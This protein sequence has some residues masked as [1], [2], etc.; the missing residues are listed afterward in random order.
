MNFFKKKSTRRAAAIISSVL[1][2]VSAFTA[3]YTALNYMRINSRG[4]SDAVVEAAK[5][6]AFSGLIAGFILIGLSVVIMIYVI[7]LGGYNENEGKFEIRMRDRVP[8]ELFFIS[9][10]A[11]IT[12]L[13]V[14][15]EMGEFS[16][17]LYEL[18]CRYKVDHTAT[19]FVITAVLTFIYTAAVFSVDSLIN[20][21]KCHCVSDTFFFTRTA[22][23]IYRKICSVIALRKN[24]FAVKFFIRLGLA[25][26][27]GVISVLIGLETGEIAVLAVLCG[28]TVYGY[29]YFSIRD[30]KDVTALTG[31]IE[32]ISRGE[33]SQEEPDPSSVI[34]SAAVRLN[35]ISD[36]IR[37][38]VEEQLRSERMKIELVTNV[39][40][41]LKT[42]LTSVIS[43]VDLL[44]KEELSPVAQDYVAVLEQK[45]DRL[46]TIVSDVFDLAKATS[47]TDVC[48]ETI[49][50]VIL[51][52]QVA[53]DMEDKIKEYGREVRLSVNAETAFIEAE[54]K[55]MYRVLQNITDNALKYSLEGT[56][57]YLQLDVNDGKVLITVKNIASYEMN[58]TPEEITERF[59][60]GDKSRTTEGS[61]LGLAIAKSFTEACGGRFI[62]SVDGDLFTAA[63]EFSVCSCEVTEK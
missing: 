45:T 44:S 42:P 39:S 37:T 29:I 60:R 38:A 34:Y 7:A 43:Y 46:K 9:S 30:I 4:Y 26:S 23:N 36:G 22:K 61:G 17:I 15:L 1:A 6:G 56:R 28:L 58:F 35:S 18:T 5:S 41:D 33:Y 40:H 20:R 50:A 13:L 52:N 16:D 25:L 47:G 24:A 55:K 3:S 54:G 19:A 51:V 21:V 27:A 62:V 48:T 31:Q 8:G 2:A 63:V 59:T 12:L 10:F 14:V 32:S 11:T 49:D 53:A 57:I